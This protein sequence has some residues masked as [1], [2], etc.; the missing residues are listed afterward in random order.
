MLLKQ[1]A[2]DAIEL[3]VSLSQLK[4][5]YRALFRQLH[6][7]GADGFDALDEDDMLLTLQ[8]YLQGKAR[9]AGIDATHHAEW[10]AF[11]EVRD[12]PGCS[13]RAA[14]RR[15]AERDDAS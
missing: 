7:A 4:K 3:R 2:N 14:R 8:T 5:I 6:Q 9:E 13:D 12:A 1:T 11:L 15:G 10:D